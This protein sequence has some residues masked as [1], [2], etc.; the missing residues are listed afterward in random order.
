MKR[1]G[2]LIGCEQEGIRMTRLQ[3]VLRVFLLSGLAAGVLGTIV[4]RTELIFQDGVRYIEQAQR[5]SRGAFSDGVLRSTDH[6]GYPLLIAAFHRIT[7]EEGP[8][9][10]QQAAQ[11]AAV[12]SGILLVVPLYLVGVELLGPSRA[13][14]GCLLLY[15][16]PVPCRVMADAMS[17]S[18]FLL[19]GCWAL[20]GA[21]R[22]FRSGR[23]QWL[24]LLVIF[25]VA[26]YLTRPEGLLLPAATVATLLLMPFLPVTRLRSGQWWTALGILV[27]APACLVGP[28]VLAKGGLGTKPAVAR[29]LG[30][31]AK[32]PADSVARARLLDPKET[33]ARTYALA[34]KGTALAV[35]ELV[36]L[37]LLPL[38]ALGLLKRRSSPSHARIRLF[39]SIIVGGSAFAFVR[40]HATCGYCTPRHTLLLGLLFFPIAAA[41]LCLLVESIALRFK[42]LDDEP[43]VDQNL[44]IAWP[45]VLVALLVVYACYSAPKLLRPLNHEGMGYRLAGE[46]LA[47]SAHAAGDAKIV[48]ASGWSLFYGQRAG[49][50][51]AN[52]TAATDDPQARFVVVREA[53]LLGPWG[54]CRYFRELVRG[55]LPIAAFP[56]HPDKTQSR[57]FVFDRLQ[58]ISPLAEGQPWSAIRR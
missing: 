47:D 22:F 57:V 4:A 41:G 20:W 39:L 6:P 49:Y 1:N 2:W 32:A 23:A 33:T 5:I 24:A 53:H 29:I 8:V 43:S 25:G 46:W 42:R 3:H 17:E 58:P 56:D 54:Y 19:F 48:D 45:V 28:Y 7:G 27:I 55:R 15:L 12:L 31:E 50:T 34:V 44:A 10:W 11:T 13:W 9:A 21:V 36:S 35:G 26:A 30:T 16:A 52:L 40:L 14:L 38:L 37:P 51:F 18:T